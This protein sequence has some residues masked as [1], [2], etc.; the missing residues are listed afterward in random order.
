MVEIK[1]SQ[2][3][4]AIT[5]STF[6]EEN[7]IECPLYETVKYMKDKPLW[8]S[9]VSIIFHGILCKADSD[10]QF[11]T[12]KEAEEKA[13]AR[14]IEIIENLEIVNGYVRGKTHA[15]QRKNL[16]EKISPNRK[17]TKIDIPVIDN[18]EDYS[19]SSIS[20]DENK[21]CISK[22]LAFRQ[23][24]PYKK[25]FLINLEDNRIKLCGL[26]QKNLYIGFIGAVH[27]YEQNKLNNWFHAENMNV[28]DVLSTTKNNKILHK[29]NEGYGDIVY[30]FMTFYIRSLIEYIGSKDSVK[31]YIVSSDNTGLCTRICA[32]VLISE[33]NM[34]NITV[35]N[36]NVI[37]SD[38][39]TRR[40]PNKDANTF[41]KAKKNVNTCKAKKKLNKPNTQ[42]KQKKMIK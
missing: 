42:R 14:L 4:N 5:L 20:D 37:P 25:I 36:T 22:S 38:V 34:K 9:V 6:C 13:S 28:S 1:Y 31:L 41:S 21:D 24:F 10:G 40:K 18:E 15:I 11:D 26:R 29:I 3:S 33:N 27:I 16:G 17:I 30:H 19:E 35:I 32:N 23:D 2:V 12:E 39:R 8:L 7:N